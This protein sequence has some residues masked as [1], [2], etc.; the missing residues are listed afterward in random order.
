MKRPAS[1]AASLRQSDDSLKL[2]RDKRMKISHQIQWEVMTLPEI[3]LYYIPNR[4]TSAI[5]HG[6]P[7]KK[8]ASRIVDAVF[9]LS[10]VGDF[11]GSQARAIIRTPD[12]LKFEIQMFRTSTDNNIMVEIQ[13]LQGDTVQFHRIALFILRSIQSASDTNS[14]GRQ[15]ENQKQFSH[16]IQPSRAP[17]I[18]VVEQNEL[19]CGERRMDDDDDEEE[20]RRFIQVLEPINTLLKK[21]RKCAILL[22]LQSLSQLTDTHSSSNCMVSLTSK[23]ILQGRSMESTSIVCQ[24]VSEAVLSLFYT[25][26]HQDDDDDDDLS[27]E[28]SSIEHLSKDQSHPWIQMSNDQASVTLSSLNERN[29]PQS[30]HVANDVTKQEDLIDSKIQNFALSILANAL[31]FM[32][33]DA[34]KSDPN[35]SILSLPSLWTDVIS[36]SMNDNRND[37]SILKDFLSKLILKMKDATCKP[38]DAY[39]AARC[40][41]YLIKSCT[42]IKLIA[43]E[44]GLTLE[45]LSQPSLCTSLATNDGIG[46][47]EDCYAE[48]TCRH[49]LLA[50][51]VLFISEELHPV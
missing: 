25:D 35:H 40:I 19:Q 32:T 30:N 29:Y 46:N 31:H 16:R 43:M 37:P 6:V 3:P 8:V 1:L 33:R 28:D 34:I 42:Q 22:G 5:L 36:A 51:T 11:D 4:T 2:L 50:E 23:A 39:Q 17:K 48:T 12:Q 44:L 10:A 21:D 38:N 9:S 49:A 47:D 20:E 41:L 45:L 27:S 13:R 18:A 24:E 26:D 14:Y 15:P 7:T